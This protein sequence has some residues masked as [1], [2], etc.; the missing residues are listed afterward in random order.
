MGIWIVLSNNI[1]LTTQIPN[2]DFSKILITPHSR[3]LN[4][5]NHPKVITLL[6]NKTICPI[7]NN[8]MSSERD[9][10]LHPRRHWSRDEVLRNPSPVPKKPGVYGWYFKQI[11]P[12]VPTDGC[13]NFEGLT[14]LYVGIAPQKP[15]RTGKKSKQNLCTR[16]RFHYDKGPS[17]G[18][19]LRL[20]LGCLLS[21][22]LRIHLQR[23]EGST[24]LTFSDGEQIL[25]SWMGEN[26]F[27]T[28]VVTDC[29]WILDE[30]LIRIISLPLNLQGDD[31]HL[32]YIHLKGIRKAY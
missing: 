15:T 23:W 32:F 18:S 9:T 17:D 29:P 4:P 14:L 5:V 25:S 31:R 6:T 12:G 7:G 22:K 3:C 20:S 21:E 11:P 19:T 28:W 27:V 8:S 1:F 24:S 16:L 10:L 13:V 2:T 26:A 30:E